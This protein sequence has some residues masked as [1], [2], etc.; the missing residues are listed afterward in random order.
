ML[1]LVTQ[2]NF[3]KAC[4]SGARERIKWVANESF[5]RQYLVVFLLEA[6]AVQFSTLVQKHLAQIIISFLTRNKAAK[7]KFI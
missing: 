1:T 4:L 2:G 6:T 7:S 3:T 5:T